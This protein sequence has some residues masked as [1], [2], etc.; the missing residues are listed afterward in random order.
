MGKIKSAKK[1]NKRIGIRKKNSVFK[2]EKNSPP[3]NVPEESNKNFITSITE[4]LPKDSDV[5]SVRSL[6]SIKNRFGIKKHISKQEKLKL[7][8]E[9]LKQK[10]DFLMES[11]NSKKSSYKAN[12]KLDTNDLVNISV[13]SKTEIVQD[14]DE[15][16]LKLGNKTKGIAKRKKRKEQMIKDTNLLK[17]LMFKKKAT[18]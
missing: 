11:V 6:K 5:M 1:P 12:P 9:I 17:N 3:Q 2:N 4:S 16:Y 18:I 15:E 8:K 13:K 7:K 14:K 10:V